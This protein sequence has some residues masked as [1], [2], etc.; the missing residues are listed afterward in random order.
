MDD[1]KRMKVFYD[2]REKDTWSIFNCYP[3]WLDCKQTWMLTKILDS[4]NLEKSTFL[5]IGA[6]E[7]NFLFKVLS[8]GI[9]YKNITAI[10]YLENRYKKLVEK[11]PHVKSINADFLSVQLEEKYDIVTLMAVLTSVTD[12]EIRYAILDKALESMSSSGM[13]ILYDYFDDS[14]K[15]F[16]ALSLSKVEALAKKYHI[17]VYKNVYMKSRYAKGLCRLNLQPLIP[18]IEAL[19]IFNDTYHFVVITNAR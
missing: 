5:D 18:L 11:L 8:F 16:R 2:S 7:G 10:E 12:N 15:F 4:K 1:L 17:E 6:G 3:Y 9:D 14:E 13:L 19:K